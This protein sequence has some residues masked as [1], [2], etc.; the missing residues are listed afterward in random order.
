MLLA[1]WCFQTGEW[2]RLSPTQIL[3]TAAEALQGRT[4]R[5]GWLKTPPVQEPT[6]WTRAHTNQENSELLAALLHVAACGLHL[7]GCIGARLGSGAA[8]LEGME[9]VPESFLWWW[10][11]GRPKMSWYVEVPGAARLSLRETFG[12]KWNVMSFV[13]FLLAEDEDIRR[14]R[15]AEP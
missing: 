2:Q 7:V 1:A 9:D 15:R 10:R 11:S 5:I 14:L 6:R 8:T 13:Q 4:L 3:M 12:E